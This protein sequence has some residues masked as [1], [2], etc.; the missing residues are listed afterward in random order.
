MAKVRARGV[1]G[2]A[3]MTLVAAARIVEIDETQR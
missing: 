2:Y 3:I 1:D